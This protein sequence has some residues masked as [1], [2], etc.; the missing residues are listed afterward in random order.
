MSSTLTP[1]PDSDDAVLCL[2]DEPTPAQIAFA[3]ARSLP[4]ALAVAAMEI[5][6][7]R[8]DLL[9]YPV[10]SPADG[11][12]LVSL[13]K[14][15]GEEAINHGTLSASLTRLGPA[16]TKLTA[17]ALQLGRSTWTAPIPRGGWGRLSKVLRNHA[18][19]SAGAYPI[20]VGS[21]VAAVFEVMSFDLLQADLATEA[22]TLEIAARLNRHTR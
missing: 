13:G 8:P 5:C 10:Y 16:G 17:H 11:V 12:P 4:D 22:L 18:I 15:F 20:V 2:R 1:P 3:G 19:Q 6:S 9:V 7:G 21:R 14:L